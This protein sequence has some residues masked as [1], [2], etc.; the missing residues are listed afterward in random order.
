MGRLRYRWRLALPLVV[1]MF[2]V[3]LTAA[4]DDTTT[5]TLTSTDALFQPLASTEAPLSA[6]FTR[7]LTISTD[8]GQPIIYVAISNTGWSSGT[9]IL[10]SEGL[11]PDAP[12]VALEVDA[13]GAPRA[14]GLAFNLPYDP[15]LEGFVL[16]VLIA[17]TRTF[18]VF[19][20]VDA[21][22]LGFAGHINVHNGNFVIQQLAE[23]MVDPEP[24]FAPLVLE[25]HIVVRLIP[26]AEPDAAEPDTPGTW[27]ACGSCD[28][29][30]HVGECLLSPASE[31]LWDPGTCG[32]VDSPQNPTPQH[33]CEPWPECADD[34]GND[35]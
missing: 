17:Q 14:G 34:G 16:E 10:V 8:T 21:E 28:T 24:V 12:Y 15:D 5:L 30:G 26:V 4:Q 33:L 31:C 29:C 2:V 35:F 27:G 23:V 3:P 22:G 18:G 32:A 20:V 7:E 9:L 25:C 1:L 6:D 13:D 19:R 11:E